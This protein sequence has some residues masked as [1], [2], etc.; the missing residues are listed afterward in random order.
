[1]V[2]QL[3]KMFPRIL[4]SLRFIQDFITISFNTLLKHELSNSTLIQ[5][6]K[7]HF[8]IILPYSHRPSEWT[9]SFMSSNQKSVDYIQS[10]ACHTPHPSCH[11]SAITLVSDKLYKLCYFTFCILFLL[12]TFS[13]FSSNIILIA[14]LQQTQLIN[15]TF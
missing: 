2:A 6:L 9:L 15:C 11:C 8:N 10:H 14:V 13:V 1:M 5:L 3:I 4:W 12:P 7:I